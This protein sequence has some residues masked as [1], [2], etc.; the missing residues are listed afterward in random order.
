MLVLGHLPRRAGQALHEIRNLQR[1]AF[2]FH[3]AGFEADE[4]E[5]IIDEF[6]QPHA[7]GVHGEQQIMHAGID[8]A[9]EALEQHFQRRKQQ[10]ERGAQFMADVGEEPALQAVQ[11]HQLPVGFL[12]LLFVPVQFIAQRELAEVQP[13][14]IIIAHHDDDARQDQEIIIVEN[15]GQLF[16]GAL[17]QAGREIHQL[18]PAHGQQRFGRVP[19]HHHA[20][21]QQDQVQSG[22]IR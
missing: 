6:E 20:D 10:R 12:E 13:G 2:D 15:D 16:P 1:L 8:L 19:A 9:G 22:V 4:V 7:V 5:Q 3:P 17:Q 11:F 21:G 18:H 14:E